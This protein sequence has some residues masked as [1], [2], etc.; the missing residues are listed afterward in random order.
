MTNFNAQ[1]NL[2]LQAL[3][4]DASRLSL[5]VET[6]RAEAYRRRGIRLARV[7]FGATSNYISRFDA[8]S[9]PK[10]TEG[11]IQGSEHEQWTLNV[12]IMQG[13]L[14]EMQDELDAST[15]GATVVI[16]GK[17]NDGAWL[18]ILLALELLLVS[19]TSV[20]GNKIA[21]YIDIPINF[22]FFIMLFGIASL[23]V[24]TI[25]LTRYREG[26]RGVTPNN[27]P[28]GS[29]RSAVDFLLSRIVTIFPLG[30]LVGSATGIL[31]TIILPPL[32]AAPVFVLPGFGGIYGYEILA[33]II[34]LPTLYAVNS[35]KKDLALLMA[36]TI[37][38]A[39]S[40]AGISVAVF[41]PT[42]S[43]YTFYTFV[44]F[45][46]LQFT[47]ILLN[48]I[49]CNVSMVLTAILIR[50]KTAQA[51]IEDIRAVFQKAVQER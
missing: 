24:V 10:A 27:S 45:D 29:L 50:S 23:L 8:L 16:S 36:Y 20:F 43:A 51:I 49:G 28:S 12:G 44:F 15:P 1:T 2:Q 26:T 3:I 6:E 9:F 37:A 41:S 25:V 47:F 42:I 5:E 22:V 18:Y 33:Y 40:I 39:T 30:I 35:Y 32:S 13:I 19:V 4:E 7:L 11:T 48:L 14:F 38:F 21:E 31:C 17:Q 34:A 46:Y